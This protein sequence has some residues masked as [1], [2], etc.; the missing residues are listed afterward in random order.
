MAETPAYPLF[1]VVVQ[2]PVL[3]VGGGAV[4][5]RKARGL[6]ESAAR[7][8][9]VSPEFHKGFDELKD[10]ERIAAPYMATHMAR[11]MWR[12]V[13]AATNVKEVNEQVFK[14]ASAAGIL[15]CRCD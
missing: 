14:H 8:T 12:L 1:L 9:V 13:F 4:A 10:V 11:K 3:I 5:L 15:C 6:I 7:V 2:C